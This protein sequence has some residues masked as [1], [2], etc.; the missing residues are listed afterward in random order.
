MTKLNSKLGQ[1]Q[2]DGGQLRKRITELS[3]QI[4]QIEEHL[5]LG[6]A[7]KD[8]Y[9]KVI[10]KI[11]RNCSNWSRNQEGDQLTDRT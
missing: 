8:L 10:S 3:N 11:R 7:K 9:E 2:W 5:A 4:E 6:V 1:K